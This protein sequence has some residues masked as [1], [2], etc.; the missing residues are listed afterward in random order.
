[1][2][3]KSLAHCFTKKESLTDEVE[4]AGMFVVLLLHPP[5]HLRLVGWGSD[6]G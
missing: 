4:N 6:L 1:M 2:K 5:L 3:R